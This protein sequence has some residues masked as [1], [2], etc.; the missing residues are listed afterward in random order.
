MVGNNPTEMLEQS[1]RQLK[2]NNTKTPKFRNEASQ[3]IS[4]M[5][6]ARLQQNMPKPSNILPPPPPPLPKCSPPKFDPINKN[7]PP[8]ITNPSEEILSIIPIDSKNDI[9]R[10]RNSINNN[11]N[12]NNRDSNKLHATNRLSYVEKCTNHNN[13]NNNECLEKS[14]IKEEANDIVDGLK[15]GK[16]PVCNKCNV[17]IIG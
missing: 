13:K 17:E 3:V 14:Q 2:I 16:R 11:N 8:I 7:L 15:N 9:C 1:V 4:A 5:L 6:E 12:N 10:K